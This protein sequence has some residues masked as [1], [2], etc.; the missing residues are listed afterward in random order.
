MPAPE[1]PA[2]QGQVNLHCAFAPLS[3]PLAF[4]S[5]RTVC[6]A[7][8][9]NVCIWNVDDNSRSL[10][11]TSVYGISKLCCNVARE[12]VAFS[13][14]GSSPQVYVY[15]M[16]PQRL[17]YRIPDV[18]EL[19]IADLA[20]SRCGSRL[21]TLCRATSRKLCMFSML[22]G[23]RLVGCDLD[24]PL[25][26]DKICVYPGHKDCIALVRSN[27]ARIVSI[28]KSYETYITRLLPSAV[29]AESD[30]SIS[31]YSWTA[32][33]HF[34]VATR[35]GLLC[36]LDGATGVLLHFC[37]SE[38]PITNIT[39]T[40]SHLVTAH[41]G[42][43]LSFWSHSPEVLPDANEG[44]TLG[45]SGFADSP[46]MSSAS[47]LYKLRKYVDLESVSQQQR[48]SHRMFGQVACIQLSPDFSLAVLTTAE[49]EVWGMDLPD[50][51]NL[52]QMS[53]SVSSEGDDEEEEVYM[54]SDS[55]QMRLLTWFHTHLVTD[56]AVLGHAQL[57]ACASADEGGRLRIWEVSRGHDAK[58]F[59]VIRFTS[60]LTSLA[61]D[62]EGRLLLAGTDSGCLHV[63]RC[64]PWKHAQVLDTLRIS[65]VG[66][67]K[68]VH[69]EAEDGL[70]LTVAAL[71][72]DHRIAFCS[73]SYRDPRVRM[74]GFLDSFASLEDI[75]FQDKENWGELSVPP[76]LLV[77][78][79]NGEVPCLYVVRAPPTNY[80]PSSKNLPSEACPIWSCT[81]SSEK[82]L[83][84]RP[85]AVTALSRHDVAIGFAGGAVKIF[86]MPTNPG[87][88]TARQHA[89]EPLLS[90]LPEG[91]HQLV[92]SLQANVEGSTLVVGCMDGSVRQLRLSDDGTHSEVFCKVLHSSY[93]GGVNK[94]ICTADCKTVIS[95]GG[96]DGVLLWS[97]PDFKVAMTT[98]AEDVEEDED[99]F[100][101][102]EFVVELDD[103][104]TTAFPVWVSPGADDGAAHSAEDQELPEEHQ[105]A[106]RLLASEVDSLRKKIR[107]LV[108][109]NNQAPDLEKLD[110]GEF[111]IDIE[112]R[113]AI[114]AKS[115]EQCDA[116]R[117]EIERENV[118]RQLVRD[119]LIKEFWEPMRGK[120][121]QITSLMS[122]LSVSNYPERTVNEEENTITRKLH[123]LRRS[124]QLEVQMLQST[125]CPEELQHDLLFAEDCFTTGRERYVVNWWPAA[126]TTAAEERLKQEEE[127]KAQKNQGGLRKKE[128]R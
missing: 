72:F 11:H 71:L 40:R 88:A 79:C 105:L 34:L 25:R 111:C 109:H 21:Y 86:P 32:S 67:A 38:R 74:M 61:S 77:T 119:R 29:P 82:R 80:E 17:L 66:V 90:L 45:P 89:A 122:N 99:T 50:K 44:F 104:N 126:G 62:S 65:E 127:I 13:E 117:A 30:F 114:A 42:N 124:E 95:T 8:A 4:L 128:S 83:S 14:G 15:S 23:K 87:T 39:L 110:R 10:L 53:Q 7:A 1:K 94:A 112:E 52:D 73:V 5:D 26:F 125:S 75:C 57:K 60:G 20:F 118:A 91:A 100:G 16:Q 92:A 35:Q 59:R 113:N 85:T 9:N 41:I 47:G 108:E 19:E 27:S 55:M 37:Q 68:V 123:L 121:C 115:K 70:G 107:I 3:A 33:G 76:K 2:K 24:L 120:G 36:T 103:R 12:L 48:P 18:A 49:G 6:F 46:S 106:R 93:S 101:D 116:L 56:I 51:T 54:R 97:N 63:L 102:E 28:T 64:T 43:T 81:L 31:A 58:G 84:D 69:C 96:S 78:G 22:T 98:E